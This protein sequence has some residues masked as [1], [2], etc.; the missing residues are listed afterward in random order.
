MVR[1]VVS[2]EVVMLRVALVMSRVTGLGCES[3]RWLC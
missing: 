2:V 1:V 3:E